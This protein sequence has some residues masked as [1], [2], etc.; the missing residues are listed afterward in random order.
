MTGLQQ[1]YLKAKQHRVEQTMW[2][3]ALYEAIYSFKCAICRQTCALSSISE[4]HTED[5]AAGGLPASLKEMDSEE[6]SLA[7]AIPAALKYQ[8][9]SKGNLVY[10]LC[11]HW[12]SRKFETYVQVNA[13]QYKSPEINPTFTKII[14]FM[15]CWGVEWTGL[16]YT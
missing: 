7:S 4:T 2:S 8:F 10:L 13:I 5:W 16:H 6:E 14:P 12:N 15:F 11:T 9:H 3:L 1:T